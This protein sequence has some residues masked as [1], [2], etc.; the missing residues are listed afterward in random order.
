[1]LSREAAHLGVAGLLVVTPA[2]NRPSQAGLYQ[3]FRAVA[4]A[5]DVPVMLYHVP[6]TTGVHLDAD[7]LR[8][9]VST[10]LSPPTP[11]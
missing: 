10:R 4:E 1:V 6:G 2:Y 8:Q 11:R 9:L 3:H 5:V 7:R